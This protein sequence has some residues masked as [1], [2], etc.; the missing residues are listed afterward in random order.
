MLF[1]KAHIYILKQFKARKKTA[2]LT[3][4]LFRI[5]KF[6]RKIR[7]LIGIAAKIYFL[8]HFSIFAVSKGLNSSAYFPSLSKTMSLGRFLVKTPSKTDVSG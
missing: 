8:S 2:I 3:S 4:F 6:F 7:L 1:S 5:I